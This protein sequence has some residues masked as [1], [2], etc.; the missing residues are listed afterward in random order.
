MLLITPH[1]VRNIVR[2]DVDKT[3]FLSGTDASM[4]QG[5][6]VSGTIGELPVARNNIPPTEASP[7][8]NPFRQLLLQGRQLPPP[9]N[10]P[11]PAPM[12]A[13]P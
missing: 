9:P 7:I 8:P 11:L 10:A 13:A 5:T 12:Q 1:V 3:E 6:G 4:G 2:P